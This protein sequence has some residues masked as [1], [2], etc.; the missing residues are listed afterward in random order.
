MT[1]EERHRQWQDPYIQ[2]CAKALRTSIY[3]AY[4]HHDKISPSKGSGAAVHV[5]IEVMETK[6]QHQATAP[7]GAPGIRLRVKR[8]VRKEPAA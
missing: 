8:K 4:L 3:E 2:E 7:K 6:E 5:R 1:D